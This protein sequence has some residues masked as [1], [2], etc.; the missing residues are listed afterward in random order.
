M[1]AGEWQCQ[2][3]ALRAESAAHLGWR[4]MGYIER[5]RYYVPSRTVWG[6]LVSA[7]AGLRHAVDGVPGMY[8]KATEAC[9]KGLRFTP[10]FP[11]ESA[12]ATGKVWRPRFETGK[13]GRAA[14]LWYGE[15][16]AA[17]FER[18]LVWS[19]ATTAIQASSQSAQDGSL[20]DVEYVAPYWR[21][22]GGIHRVFWAG[23]VFFRDPIDEVVLGRAFELIE[24]GGERR[25]GWGQFRRAGA[26]AVAAGDAI[27][28]EFVF[29]AG[30]GSSP[31]I[32]ARGTDYA[33]PAHL[34]FDAERTGLTGDLEAVGGRDW[35]G[36]GPGRKPAGA[37]LCWAP[38]TCGEGPA[39]FEVDEHGYWRF[40]GAKTNAGFSGD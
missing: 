9:G 6:A 14:G 34:E 2:R 33:L 3:V 8:V 38:G 40:A 15:M 18:K 13:N 37:K 25:Y 29:E 17:E 12:D 22:S 19:H 31:K 23:Y 16:P 35:Y 32:A 5:T 10:F 1:S 20:H 28:D 21:E 36:D 11:A 26:P 27:F 4:R 7:I 30:S 39:E 24:F